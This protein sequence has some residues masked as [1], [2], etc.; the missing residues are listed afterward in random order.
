MKNHS[1]FSYLILIVS[2]FH[3]RAEAFRLEPMVVNFSPD[4]AGASKIF[5]IENEAKEKI[6][7]KVEAFTREIDDK[8]KEKMTPSR[9][10]KIYPD[11]ISLN[12]SDSRA[13]RVVYLGPKDI[14][15]E[16]AYRI[17]A[18]QLP[19]SFEESKKQTGIKFLFQFVASVYVTDVNYYPKI[20]IEPIKRLDK[21]TLRISVVNKG[22]RHTLLKNV[23][24]EMKDNAGKTVNLAELVKDWDGEN[25]LSGRRRV[26]KVKTTS[27]FDLVKN[28]PK[29]EIKDENITP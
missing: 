11:Q 25:L 27:E 23:K 20:V 4:G 12:G 28:P 5:R 13:I 17:V 2:V 10:F 21:D 18:S 3:F 24:I 9:D 29:V 26:F 16:V 14:D 15:K 1:L 7:V 19:V 22:Q 6:A 8:G